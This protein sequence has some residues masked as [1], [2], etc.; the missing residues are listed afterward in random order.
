[1]LRFRGSLGH[2]LLR[3][4]MDPTV[5]IGNLADLIGRLERAGSAF[6]RPGDWQ[7]AQNGYLQVVETVERQL[8]SLFE[9][10]DGT[11]AGLFGEQYR[12]IREMSASTPRSEPLI[13]LEA[14]R[15]AAALQRLVSDVTALRALRDREGVPVVLDTNI[16][17]HYHRP[18]RVLWVEVIGSDLVR[19]VLPICVL[20]EL[21]NKKYA[22]SDRM[23]RRADMAVRALRE[24][25]ADLVPG[26]AATFANGTTCEVFLDEA[27]HV[28]KA[29]PDEE[30]LSRAL[31][32]QRAL[33]RQ[34]TVVTGDLCMQLRAGAIGLAEA[35]MPAKYSKDTERRKKAPEDE[36]P[37]A[38]EV[39]VA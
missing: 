12:M 34:V 30:L 1:L 36:E 11:A 6:A 31:T 14:G 3:E 26:S 27:S 9:D 4:G 22:D 13:G 38:P 39:P 33:G 20:D 23:S 19:L 35:V 28:R 18:D 25:R 37:A 21:D 2:M 24:H 32:L 16:L 10:D 15:Q 17:M 29:N 7:A 5:A 8:A